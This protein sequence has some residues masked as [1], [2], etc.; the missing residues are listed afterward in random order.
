MAL[1][2]T[3]MMVQMGY[4]TGASEVRSQMDIMDK[5]LGTISIKNDRTTPRGRPSGPHQRK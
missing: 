4:P 1:N 2:N 3:L 5:T